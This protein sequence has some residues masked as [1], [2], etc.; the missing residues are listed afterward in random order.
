MFALRT[1]YTMN[2]LRTFS[3][4]FSFVSICVYRAK[5]HTQ[6][7]CVYSS[8]RPRLFVLWAAICNECNMV[9]KT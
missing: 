5:A 9:K 1:S 8:F 4:N 6:Y 3:D 2:C 7:W